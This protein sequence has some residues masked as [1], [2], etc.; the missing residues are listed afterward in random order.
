MKPEEV[1]DAEGNGQSLIT[2]LADVTA[3]TLY[4]WSN[5]LL[6]TRMCR[7]ELLRQLG[8]RS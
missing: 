7:D 6:T 1:V 8:R 3:A 4:T 2:L 5:A